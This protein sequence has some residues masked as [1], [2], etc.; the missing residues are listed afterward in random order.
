MLELD[1]CALWGHRTPDESFLLIFPRAVYTMLEQPAAAKSGSSSLRQ[2]AWRSIALIATKYDQSVSIIGGLVRLLLGCEH[3]AAPLAELMQSL[4]EE[5]SAVRLVADLLSELAGLAPSEMGVD[6]AGPKNV[7]TFLQAVAARAPLMLVVNLHL[8]QPHLD[9]ESYALRCGAVSAFGELMIQ[10]ATLQGTPPEIAEAASGLLSTPLQRLSDVSSFVRC[11]ALNTIGLLCEARALPMAAFHDVAVQG[12]L[13]L[14]DKN[15]NVRRSA[16]Q[17][18]ATLLEF[19]PFC[20]ALPREQLEQRRESLLQESAAD[21]ASAVISSPDELELAEGTG[22]S[23]QE[24]K[25]SRERSAALALLEKA[26]AFEEVMARQL[27]IVM[28]LL[29]SQTNSDVVEAMNAVVAGHSFE[30]QVRI[31][32]SPAPSFLCPHLY[33]CPNCLPP[34]VGVQGA[35]PSVILTLVWS[36]EPAIKDAALKCVQ[37]THTIRTISRLTKSIHCSCLAAPLIR[38]VFLI[39]RT[40]ASSKPNPFFFVVGCVAALTD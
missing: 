35:R 14:T 30:L 5:H 6:S 12:L 7:S 23:A 24:S 26:L 20:P 8:L 21:K 13:R 22:V 27:L 32:P 39:G 10:V 29:S 1:L 2:A 38:L 11:R 34:V 40:L 25:G 28:Q 4:L 33:W 3:L 18:F 31:L 9:S 37:V 16:L 36:R 15:A 19:N 17:L